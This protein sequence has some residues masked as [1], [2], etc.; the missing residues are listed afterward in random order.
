MT[1]SQ[2]KAA[3]KFLE[4][5]TFQRGSEK[6]EDQQFWNSL[7]RDVLG[8]TDV[9]Q[10]IKYQVPV[11]LKNATMFLDAWIPETRVLIEHKSR[12]I[13]LTRNA[14]RRELITHR[15]YSLG[16][17]S[18]YWYSTG[19]DLIGRPTNATDSVS[20]M[21]EWLYNNRS[22]LASATIGMNQYGYSYDTI[23]NR[24]WSADNAV[25]NSY[26]ANNLNQY[27]TILRASAPPREP[28][29]DADGNMT[30]DGVFAYAYDAENR[31]VAVTSAS[32]TNGAIR[33]LNA[34]DHRNRRIRK[35][36]QRLHS[37]SAPPPAP[38]SG[39]DEWLTLE[40]HTLVWDGNNIILEKVEFADGTTRTFEYFWGLDKSGTEQGAGGVGGLLAVS[41]DGV[42][43]IPCYDHNGNIVLYISETGSSVAQYTYDPYGNIIESS[44]PFSDQFS[45][46]FSTKYHDREVGMIGYKRRFYR[47]DL[48]RWLNRDPI[49]ES[50]GENLYAF[51]ANSPI[52][53]Y[54][55]D[56]MITWGNVLSGVVQMASGVMLGITSVTSLISSGGMSTPMAV[57]LGAW[58]TMTFMNGYNTLTAALNDKGP[59]EA[60]QVRIVESVYTL[61]TGEQMGETGLTI[62]RYCYYSVDIACSCYSINFTWK[63]YFKS[64]RTFIPEY[65]SEA[66]YFTRSGMKVLKAESSMRFIGT[67]MGAGIQTGSIILDSHSIFLDVNSIMPDD[68]PVF[69]NPDVGYGRK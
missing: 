53:Y 51:C 56:G 2:K 23:G 36:V 28:T 67:V 45:F 12:G 41:M 16:S 19:Y 69:I 11:Q 61:V 27:T 66:Q 25:T 62:T 22:E 40:T 54:D 1:V 21:R 10:H 49:E 43:Y 26:T 46:G 30:G 9:E 59:P 4:Y 8:V 50:G 63:S 18:V 58:A 57:S 35:T 7:L 47:P 48:G 52:R 39:T 6:G 13:N 33:V 15:D 34:Y 65:G 44:G 38:P 64:R 3:R 5:W 37:T 55:I 20:L 42:F 32:L 14:S 24:R 31:L 29:Y 17:Q 60:I 68:E